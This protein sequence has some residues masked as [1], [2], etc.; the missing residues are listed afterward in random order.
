M[1]IENAQFYQGAGR[2]AGKH[3]H[4]AGFEP[5]RPGIARVAVGHQ[6]RHAVS[7]IV[8][9]A[10]VYAELIAPNDEGEYQASFSTE[11]EII[12][13]I[14]FRVVAQDK[15]MPR[16]AGRVVNSSRHAILVEVGGG[17]GQRFSNDHRVMRRTL[18]WIELV[19]D[20]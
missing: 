13:D 14:P 6:L 3:I 11:V 1:G 19:A 7:Q 5:D 4:Y 16:W 10:I 20:E 8:E 15:P 2:W 9:H 12:P 17:N 18:Q